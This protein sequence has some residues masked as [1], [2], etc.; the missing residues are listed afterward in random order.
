MNQFKG[1]GKVSSKPKKSGRSCVW[2]VLELDEDGYTSW[3]GMKFWGA[4]ARNITK[5]NIGDVVKVQGR[6]AQQKWE[7]KYRLSAH[8]N[9]C[10]LCTET[11][12]TFQAMSENPAPFMNL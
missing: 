2:A 12:D 7:G 4:A 6:L 9:T 8:I 11:K 3:I 5:A 1:K 10:E